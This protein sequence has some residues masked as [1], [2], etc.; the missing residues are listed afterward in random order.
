MTD[1]E[2]YSE[3]SEGVVTNDCGNEVSPFDDD[4]DYYKSELDNLTNP[5]SDDYNKYDNE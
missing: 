1:R 3:Y 5:L 2:R 4:Y